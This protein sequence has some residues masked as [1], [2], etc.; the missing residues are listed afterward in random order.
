M[1]FQTWL[2]KARDVRDL[3]IVPDGD[4]TVTITGFVFDKVNNYERLT[5]RFEIDGLGQCIPDKI[6]FL[7]PTGDDNPELT[8][9]VLI[10]LR[11]FYACFGV[12]IDTCQNDPEVFLRKRGK[13]RIETDTKGY[14]NVVKFYKKDFLENAPASEYARRASQ[15]R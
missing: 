8:R 9:G 2:S 12:D 6:H 10:R 14:K 7:F 13:I 15:S 4:Y 1:D 3:T 5:Y 11:M